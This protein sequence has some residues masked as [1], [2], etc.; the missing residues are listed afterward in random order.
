MNNIP[1]VLLYAFLFLIALYYFL[2]TE[3]GLLKW[4]MLCFVFLP[5][6][7]LIKAVL[8]FNSHLAPFVVV[9]FL[10]APALFWWHLTKSSEVEKRDRL[11]G[12]LF[13]I[14]FILHVLAMLFFKP[15]GFV[16]AILAP[17]SL[18]I[19]I[20]YTLKYKDSPYF[21]NELRL[22]NLFGIQLVLMCM[23]AIGRWMDLF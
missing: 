1:E 21:T 6:P 17:L 18:G 7:F 4:A 11:W 22:M 16:G 2:Y 9:G 12:K 13:L 20:Y 10:I 19:W 3:K 5:L 8:Q 14:P 15:L 23:K